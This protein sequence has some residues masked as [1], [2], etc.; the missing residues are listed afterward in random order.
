MVF[1]ITGRI[2]ILG[3][4]AFVARP[5]VGMGVTKAATDAAALAEALAAHPGDVPLALAAF[6][7]E[8]L[9]YGAAVV[10]RAR[11]LGGYLRVQHM[12]DAE[13]ALA[14]RHRDPHAVMAETAVTTGIV[15]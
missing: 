3:D 5:H 12:T 1:G 2:V 14:E 6:E 9:A 4:A 8:R 15:P 10:R 13:R 11:D 7:K